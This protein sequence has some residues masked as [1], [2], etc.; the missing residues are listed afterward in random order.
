[1]TKSQTVLKFYGNCEYVD[2]GNNASLNL[3]QAITLE[4]WFLFMGDMYNEG[5]SI[6]HKWGYGNKGDLGGYYLGIKPGNKKVFWKLCLDKGSWYCE[7]SPL[8]TSKWTHIAGTYNGKVLKLFYNG[9]QVS[10][11]ETSGQIRT[12]DANFQMGQSDDIDYEDLEQQWIG[13]LSEVRLWNIARESSEIQGSLAH[14]LGG[15]EPG[16]VAYWPLDD[17]DPVSG[18]GEIVHDRG[19]Q[20]IHGTTDAT[21]ETDDQLLLAPAEE[22]IS[23]SAS[24]IMAGEELSESPESVL[25]LNG[26]GDEEL[27][28]AINE[29]NTTS[30]LSFDGKNDYVIAPATDWKPEA[31]SLEL[32]ARARTAKQKG[33]TSLFSNYD[34]SYPRGSFQVDIW[35]GKYRFC[36]NPE[37]A[38]LY[39]GPVKTT[40]QHLAIT[41]DGETIR[42]YL[43]GQAMGD[44]EFAIKT[45]FK[46]YVLGRNRSANKYF[47]G[48]LTEVRVWDKALTPEEI[49]ANRSHRLTGNEPGL[50]AYWPL[51]EGSGDT[52][53]DRSPNGN[54]GTIHGATWEIAHWQ[55]LSPLAPMEALSDQEEP[56]VMTASPPRS[57]SAEPTPESVST[58]ITPGIEEPPAMTESPT[59]SQSAETTTP[60]SVSTTITQKG[61]DEMTPATPAETAAVT[62]TTDKQHKPVAQ[63]RT[64]TVGLEDYVYWWKEVAKEQAEKGKEKKAFRRGRIWA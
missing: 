27:A 34:G 25:S 11:K 15:N 45:T 46:D 47:A 51:D 26:E 16:L 52:V 8:P 61:I 6:A 1:M 23:E 22:P 63:P 18:E 42:T 17:G 55:W 3:T 35:K 60:E 4:V 29:N 62:S 54:H 58:T 21:W 64:M 32:W 53:G 9:K 14:R 33:Y 48:Q 5:V 37:A 12:T 49:Q 10:S 2:C 57:Q 39:I 40:W 31:F 36:Y 50:V 43:D 7:A 41:F 30:V 19:P 56:P 28:Q 13:R 59:D 20:G 44:K 38:N 24:P